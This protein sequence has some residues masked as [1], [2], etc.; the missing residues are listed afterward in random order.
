MRIR[1]FRK[2]V[3]GIVGICLAFCVYLP[4]AG[5]QSADDFALSYPELLC[6]KED[7][8]PLLVVDNRKYGYPPF[9]GGTFTIDWGDGTVETAVSS[10]MEHRYAGF[11]VHRFTLTYTEGGSS[12]SRT[13]EVDLR[14]WYTTGFR[15]TAAG[16]CVDSE[17]K[18]EI[19]AYDKKTPETRYEMWLGGTLA[20]AWTYDEVIASGGVVGHTFHEEMCNSPVTLK[21]LD[22]CSEA[23]GELDQPSI[24][25][26]VLKPVK[27]DF[28]FEQEPVCTGIPFK[29]FVRNQQGNACG[30]KISYEWEFAGN[31]RY[32]GEEVTVL[33]YRKAD[34][35]EVKLTATIEGY[36]CATTQA[37]PK[38]LEVIERA[39]ADFSP[40]REEYCLIAG[41]LPDVRLTDRSSG[42]NI[43]VD[44]MINDRAEHNGKG[45]WTYQPAAPGVYTIEQ[46][47]RN[48]CSDSLWTETVKVKQDPDIVKLQLPDTICARQLQVTAE[49]AVFVW[50]GNPPRVSWHITG[51][52][53]TSVRQEEI[54]PVIDFKEA[55]EYTVEA[56]LGN[57]DC[58]G[59]TLKRQAKVYVV[60]TTITG[61]L[62]SSKPLENGRLSVCDQETV[63]FENHL[64]GEQLTNNWMFIPAG[65][66]A[67]LTVE[68][69]NGTSWNSSSPVFRFG[70]YGDGVLTN[71]VV[72]RLGC[73]SRTWTFPVHVGKA[74][75]IS[76]FEFAG[77]T[78]IC[79]GTTLNMADYV[80]CDWYNNE[81]RFEWSVDPGGVTGDFT[82]NYPELTFPDAGIYTIK[83]ELLDKGCSDAS[84]QSEKAITIRVRQR[85][86]DARVRLQQEGETLCEGIR[87]QILNTAR[88][89][90]GASLVY[91]WKIV[92]NGTEEEIP[93]TH[94]AILSRIFEKYGDYKVV[95]RVTGYCDVKT[96]SVEFTIHKNPK[97]DL[98]DTIV[99]PG[100]LRLEDFV[101]YE[102]YNNGEHTVSWEIRGPE[103]GYEGDLNTLYPELHLHKAGD[104][105]VKVSLPSAGCT[106]GEDTRTAERTYHVYD[107]VIGGDIVLRSG[108]GEAVA[109]DICENETVTF[110]N[111]TYAEEYIAWEWWVEGGEPEDYALEDAHR[112]EPVITFFRY[113]DYRVNVR[114]TAKCNVKTMSF[115][116]KVRG[117]PDITFDDRL[118]RICA[119]NGVPV[120]L[121]HYVHYNDRKNSDIR[122]EW[123]VDPGTGFSWEPGYGPGSEYPRVLFTDNARYLLR[124][125]AYSQ[126]AE[127]GRQEWTGKIDVISDRMKAAF[128]VGK[129]SVGCVNDPQPYEFVLENRSQGDSLEYTWTVLPEQGRSWVSGDGQAESPRL[130]ITEE[131]DYTVRLQVT[132]GCN[133]DDTVFRIRAFAVPEVNIADISDE[134]EPFHFIGKER[135]QVNLHNDALQAAQWTVT[136][137]PDYTSEGYEPVNGTDLQMF[138]PDI[139]F[140]TC[141]YT[142]RVVYRNRCITPG[143]ASFRVRVDKFVPVVPLMDEEICELTEARPL[144]AEPAGGIWSLKDPGIDGA[145]DILYRREGVYYFN[146][147]F[148]AYEEKDVELIY[149]FRNLTCVARDTM[150]MHV[151]PLPFVEAGLPLEMCL[152]HEPLL[153]SGRDS[154]SGDRW[155]TNRGT[156]ELAGEILPGHSFPA[157]GSGDF[158]LKYTY[159]D[160]HTCRNTDSVVM[161]VHPLPSTA[162]IV[163]EKNCIYTPVLFT[164][165]GSEGNIF[166][167]DFGDGRTARSAD[168]VTHIYDHYGYRQVVCRAESRYGCKDTSAARTIEIINLPPPAYF[169]VDTLKGCPPLNVRITLDPSV[170]VSDHNY[171]SFHW[172]YGE[173]T[174]TDSLMPVVPKYYP[175]GLW[176]TTYVTRFTVSNMCGSRSYDTT[177]AV[178]SRPSVSFALMHE[179]ECSPV[180]L[181]LQN[182][183]TGNNCV[184]DWS[185]INGRTG[186]EVGRSSAANPVYEFQ[187]D[188]AAT[189]FYIRLK[190][191]NACDEDIFT[192]SLLVKP[193]SISAHFTPLKHPYACEQE[194]LFFRNNSSDTVATILNTYWNFGDGERDTAWS[195]RHSYEKAG[196]YLVSLKIDNGCGWDTVSSPVTVY[197]LP[198]LEIRSEDYVC[199]ADTF[200]FV[201]KSDQELAR[202]EWDFGDGYRSYRDSVRYTYGGYGT[203]PVKVKGVSAA[204]NQC[205]DSV[206]K[207][208]TVYN[209]PLVTILPLDTAHCSPL[210]YKP[211][212]EAEGVNF[213]EWD[214]GDGSG[215]VSVGEHLYENTTDEVQHYT[216]RVKVETDKGCRKEYIRPVTLYHVPRARMEKEVTKGKPET[217]RYLNLSE[218]YTDC[219]WKLPSG[220]ERHGMGDWQLEFEKNGVYE[221]TLVA[222]NYY[223]CRDSVALEHEVL[224]KGL[225]FPN[226]F[227]PHS[228][229]EKVNRFNGIG[230]GIREYCLEIYDQYGNKI[231]ETRE[232][233]D[234]IP[235]EGWDG[236]SL[237]GERMPQG[238]YMWRARAIFGDDDVWTGKNNAS[239]VEQTVQGSVL[240]LRE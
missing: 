60:D 193:R 25:V 159:T 63:S 82:R 166:E 86:L 88:D 150:H 35:Y 163:E 101:S 81:P 18:F 87:L 232:L 50:N 6:S 221:V 109:G 75:T 65:P 4:E 11:G 218:G 69:V 145:N 196:V 139:D 20:D 54:Y 99:C 30:R 70:G 194:E 114:I 71:T 127:N 197:P 214:F 224:M 188:S 186:E 1:W 8:V 231:W 170:Y 91:D 106:E 7:I 119:G 112:A 158:K 168:T 126:C 164:P 187:T 143:T 117:I 142:V 57:F 64:G 17:V 26:T 156:W 169:D 77:D 152:N 131:G 122:V 216:V 181:E 209:K 215:P 184:Y 129:D 105:T 118:G 43:Q 33:P 12:V 104:Y 217:V 240:L 135:V 140:R 56:D 113:G 47:V 28:E 235:A 58:G 100:L 230:M 153:L 62:V 3:K 212:V 201:L 219:I 22:A 165:A 229:N 121:S 36:A 144:R 2:Q 124:L 162:F 189:T 205:T 53:G 173:G 108:T 89:I 239:G 171:L 210:Y 102:W 222:L 198:H 90:E 151:W 177:I 125:A 141:D 73:N 44:W 234:G 49:E 67:T 40:D 220:E 42:K 72:T 179:W 61:T 94:L 182:T 225:F 190:A 226:T 23:T 203:F 80:Y 59:T 176:D 228:K 199:E 27:F 195:P 137:N 211:L 207:Q 24:P 202:I 206:S 5:A 238:V 74:P 51:P 14:R 15:V 29:A 84:T 37:E 204:I 68:P 120:D 92:R 172:D 160:T 34:T 154:V 13:Y 110:V 111:T 45:N 76:I 223:G 66:T 46:Y 115:P 191:V 180:L 55:G 9:E 93:E 192:D 83:L 96:D 136:A 146:P 41:N 38:M 183:T 128:H 185:F 227:I 147:R 236:T 95:G 149:S 133:E 157:V 116:V 10:K 85:G 52:G 78:L 148:T 21:A 178:Y 237:K 39:V 200:T 130:Q 134:C 79:S 138:Y 16:N 213:F 31:G 167:W 98:R 155:E 19:V 161:T 175:S 32:E 174:R 132:N 233:Q 123:T 48:S 208:V 107:T 103:N 97:V